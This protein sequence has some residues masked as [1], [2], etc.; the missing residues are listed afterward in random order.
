MQLFPRIAELIDDLPAG[1]VRQVQVGLLWTAVV[2]EVE[3]KLQGG[4]AASLRNSEYAHT[5]RAAVNAAG[6][7][8]Q[9][10]SRQLADLIHAESHTEAAVGMTAINAL[11]PRQPERWVDLGAEEYLARHGAGK[12]VAV[13]GHFAFVEQLRAQMKNLWVLELEPR[14]GDLPAEAAPEVIPQADLIAITGTTLINHTFEGL[15]SLRSPDARL[16]LLG[17]STPLS[18]LLFDWG[19][20]VICGTQV[21]DPLVVAHMAAQGA[22]T[23]QMKP[24]LRQVTMLKKD[25]NPSLIRKIHS[26]DS[27]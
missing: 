4:I 1:I 10:T 17:P 8:E 9:Y 20:D 14:P 6:N 24:Y 25:C 15:L 11:L 3:G 12:N 26:A 2:M 16:M 5:R 13:V 19:V 23:R 18:P 22:S 27:K 7:L 21:Q